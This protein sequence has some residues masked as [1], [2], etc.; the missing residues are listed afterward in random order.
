MDTGGKQCEED[1]ATANDEQDDRFVVDFSSL[2]LKGVLAETP[3][4]DD[5][6]WYRDP[7]N[8]PN[9][10][11]Y[12]VEKLIGCGGFGAVYRANS[13]NPNRTVAVK[14]LKPD[15][16]GS[17]EAVQLFLDEIQIGASLNHIHVT[18][19]YETGVLD[20]SP[21]VGSP[22]MVM[23]FLA[24]GNFLDWL[25]QHPRTNRRDNNLRKSVI[26]L[27][28]VCQGLETLHKAGIIHRDIKPENILLDQ[29]GNPKLADF[30]LAGV[31]GETTLLH[32]REDSGDSTV[33]RSGFER[34][35]APR[36][37]QDIRGTIGYMAPELFSDVN[38]VGPH[39]DQYA[40]GIILYQVLCNLRPFQESMADPKETDRIMTQTRKSRP[41][42]P[43]SSKAK[44]RDGGLQYICLKC[45]SPNPNGR[46]Q[47]IG[48]F[49]DDLEKWL[50]GEWVGPQ[51]C[52]REW[53]ERVYLPVKR[54]PFKAL[55]LSALLFGTTTFI[56]TEFYRS[57]LAQEVEQF[58]VGYRHAQKELA[59]RQVEISENL[60]FFPETR[61]VREEQ[62]RSAL[63]RYR[64]LVQAPVVDP[65][66]D[67]ERA[68]LSSKLGDLDRE[69]MDYSSAIRDYHR[70]VDIISKTLDSGLFSEQQRLD[71]RVEKL[72]IEIQIGVCHGM[73]GDDARAESVFRRSIDQATKLVSRTES[74]EPIQALAS[75]KLIYA[76][77]LLTLGGPYEL[78]L[79]NALE[80][81]EM[82]DKID[83]QTDLENS[84]SVVKGIDLIG[85]IQLKLGD[86]QAALASFDRAIARAIDFG[87]HESDSPRLLDSLATTLESTARVYRQLERPWKQLECIGL[88]VNKFRLRAGAQP[89]SLDAQTSL[90]RSL[91]HLGITLHEL[92]LNPNADPPLREAE[93]ILMTIQQERVDVP[94]VN[95]S[96]A[97]CQDARGQVLLDLNLDPS[98][99]FWVTLDACANASRETDWSI[100]AAVFKSHL[101]RSARAVELAASPTAVT[102]Q[103]LEPRAVV[104][105]YFQEATQT[106][107]S[108]VGL[109]PHQADACNV[110]AHVYYERAMAQQDPNS[111]TAILWF[112]QARD[113]WMSLGDRSTDQS[114]DLIWLLISCPA[115]SLRDL[116]LA[117]ELCQTLIEQAESSS[118]LPPNSYLLHTFALVRALNNDFPESEML[119]E[120]CQ[121]LEGNRVDHEWLMQAYVLGE[122]NMKDGAIN[123]FELGRGAMMEGRPMNRR[124]KWILRLASESIHNIS[125]ELPIQSK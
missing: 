115:E 80:G 60:K 54:Q 27:I 24:G 107:E 84:I 83:E 4:F 116:P 28:Q 45:L 22:Y 38:S 73:Q 99:S 13:M 95:R 82:F 11:G 30:G 20:K 104:E 1:D 74:T 121:Q 43:P 47:T 19:V 64:T 123:A 72:R 29:E 40:I 32:Q 78:A 56:V 55:L 52:V 120:R 15:L 12:V 3:Q 119:I 94:V 37:A 63:R 70:A 86:H 79:R 108:I 62:I 6:D 124:S 31:I 14:V 58:R 39:S 46:Y 2:G 66:L 109:N 48:L 65:V 110:L 81:V 91:I 50:H 5:D 8:W 101:A 10:N 18:H 21:Y 23:E 97:T 7:Q 49:A 35:I 98:E 122:L 16:L 112:E 111:A 51:R 100:P 75:S 68:R 77:H 33:E 41:P 89:D 118:K 36:G 9:I 96:L 102:E 113:S 106:L 53:N 88:A 105:R 87:E 103:S 61:E 85:R 59:R 92:G 125:T 42:Q 71:C 90:A 57:S 93:D 25:N 76:D 34:L 114:L 117:R 26:K 17:P 69:L 67:I 44:F